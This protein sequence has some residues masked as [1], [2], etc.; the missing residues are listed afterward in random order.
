MQ[1]TQ[2]TKPHLCI[3]EWNSPTP[4]RKQ[5][6]LMQEGLGRVIPGGEGPGYG[7]NV[8]RPEVFSAIPYSAYDPPRKLQWY[9]TYL[10]LL[11]VPAQPEQKSASIW[12]LA[13]V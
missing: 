13:D 9:W 11:V 2:G 10:D 4:V 5:F 3:I 8:W 12:V 1:F 7:I 6:S